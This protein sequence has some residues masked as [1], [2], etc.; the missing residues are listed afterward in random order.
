[1][2]R[3]RSNEE[4]TVV[5]GGQEEMLPTLLH[6]APCGLLAQRSTL[7]H[8][9]CLPHGGHD[10]VEPLVLFLIL[11]MQLGGRGGGGGAVSDAPAST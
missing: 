9:F 4:K 1:M 6:R 8:H 11:L 3:V 7:T 10:N 5:Q 2:R